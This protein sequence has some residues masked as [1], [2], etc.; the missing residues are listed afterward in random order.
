MRTV[1]ATRFIEIPEGVEVT[2]KARVVTVKGPRGELTK[3]FKSR[4]MDIVKVSNKRIRVDIWGGKR[5]ELACLRTTTAH[6]ENMITGLTKGFKY[7]MRFVY[8]H[9]PING[10]V[11]GKP[12]NDHKIEIRNF[13]GEKRNR[14]VSAEDGVTIV[15]S[16]DVKDQIEVSG[17]DL[18]AVSL[19]CSNISSATRVRNKDIRKFLDGVYVSEKGFVVEEE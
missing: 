7:K 12:G 14:I 3:A 13:L 18:N 5:K 1:L 9:F 4:S 17:N 8:A 2:V 16:S 6:I 11:V 19:T 15:K 10:T